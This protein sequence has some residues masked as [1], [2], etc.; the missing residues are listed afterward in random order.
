MIRFLASRALAKSKYFHFHW[1]GVGM[2]CK[3]S[4]SEF[5]C[6]ATLL[7]RRP[8]RNIQPNELV[9]CRIWTTI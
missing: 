7:Y 5:A 2:N 9:R 4:N 3:S 6:Y 1:L 8:T